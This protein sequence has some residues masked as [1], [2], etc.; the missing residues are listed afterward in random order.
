MGSYAKNLER[1]LQGRAV[2]SPT[3]LYPRQS[4][5]EDRTTSHK[6]IK[7]GPGNP[8]EIVRI[9][10][11]EKPIWNGEATCGPWGIG[12]HEPEL[13]NLSWKYKRELREIPEPEDEGIPFHHGLLCGLLLDL[14]HIQTWCPY[15]DTWDALY[16]AGFRLNIYEV[17]GDQ[18][19]CGRTQVAFYPRNAKLVGEADMHWFRRW[20]A[21]CTN[22]ENTWDADTAPQ[23]TSS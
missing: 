7:V 9:Y 5:K 23:Q 22:L 21:Y 3:L 12:I 20:R 11:M 14:R 6:P 15:L 8:D 17:P 13:E 1:R 2:L 18:V 4:L 16:E 19:Y 10:R